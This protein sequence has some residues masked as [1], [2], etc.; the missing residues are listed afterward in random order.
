MKVFLAETSALCYNKMN[1]A[2][3]SL[4]WWQNTDQEVT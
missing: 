1:Y 2:G 3:V 4:P